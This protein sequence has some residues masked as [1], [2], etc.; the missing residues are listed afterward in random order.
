MFFFK[1]FN[2]DKYFIYTAKNRSSEYKINSWYKRMYRNKIFQDFFKKIV[3][4]KNAAR[5]MGSWC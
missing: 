5:L 1:S 2:N 3:H 4:S